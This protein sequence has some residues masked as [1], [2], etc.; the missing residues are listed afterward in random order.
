MAYTTLMMNTRLALISICLC[1]MGLPSGADTLAILPETLTLRGAKATQKILVEQQ[2]GTQWTGD[3]TARAAFA[4]SNP[5]IV[6]IDKTGT[7]KAVGDGTATVSAT[8]N[9]QTATKTVTVSGT[10][11]PFVWSFR[12]H[13]LPILTRNGCNQGACHGALAGKGGLKLTLRGYDPDADFAVLTRQASGRRIVSGEPQNSLLLQKSAYLVPHGGGMRLDKKSADFAVVAEWIQQGNPRPKPNDPQMAALEV[14]PKETH[15]LKPTDTQQ[16]LV[17]AAYSDRVRA[18]VT[19]WT[20][21]GTS[22]S[23]VASVDES[24]KVTVNG[25]GEAA[26]TV[27]FNSRV[28][29]ARIIVPYPNEVAESVFTSAP[30]ANFIDNAVLK[31]LSALRIPPSPRSSDQEFIRRAALDTLGLLPTV[32]E[33]E[34]FVSS[35]IPDKRKMLV[36]A[37]LARPEFVD[38]WTYKWSDLLLVSSRKLSPNAVTA[39]SGY[40]RQ[41][42]AQ[43]K[44]WDTFVREIITARGSTLEN[45][46]ANYY[47]LHKEPLELTETTTQAFL[48]MSLTCARC[49]NHPLEKWTQNQYY[50]MA[51]FMARVRLKNGEQDGEVLVLTSDQGDVT[52]PRLNRPLPPAPLDGKGIALGAKGDRRE[53]LA[54]WLTDKDNPYFSRALV[55]RVW[56][57]FMGRGL[58]EAE[59]DLRATNPPSNEELLAQLSTTFAAEKFDIRQ[60]IRTIMNSEAYQR[61][62]TPIAGNEGDNTFYSRTIVRRLPAEVMLDVLSQVTGIATEFPNMAKGTRAL[63]LNDSQTVSTFL[64]AFGRPE[65]V[66]TCACERQ[67]EP[68]VAQALHLANGDTVNLKLRASG[69]LLDALL[70]ANAS[71][72]EVLERLYK[73][74]LSRPPS[75]TEQAKALAILN[76]LPDTSRPARRVVLEDLFWAVLTD[77]E[78]LF[79]H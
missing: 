27:W 30:R 57:H 46:A 60:L 68:S 70:D 23:T 79:N 2:S 35:T 33:T 75:S 61:T 76:G 12:N 72:A 64:T 21:F 9:G 39:F 48:G 55:N 41:S 37:L 67:H 58:V 31:K 34:A 43:N 74:A 56:K 24:G 77:K 6:T 5:Q 73:T 47:V 51:N 59:D 52:H 22:D 4:T 16:I 49:H 1:A 62:A 8:L 25:Y 69:G 54:R 19:R 10:Q 15:A 17:Q 44:P 53:V 45:G 11:S 29:F 63:Q 18:D 20:K 36:E 28:A 7:I 26:I 50:E 38:Y 14:F 71:N 32:A 40:I 42:V 66:Q 65:R 3:R 78:F 13:V